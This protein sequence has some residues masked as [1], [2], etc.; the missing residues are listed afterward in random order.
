MGRA[1]H[2]HG[3]R[4][5][6]KAY[7][8]AVLSLLSFP[9]MAQETLVDRIAA[10]V[11][12]KPVMYSEIQK[13]IKKGQPVSLSQYPAKDSDS[14]YDKALNDEINY[15]LVLQKIEEFEIEISDADVD[16]EIQAFLKQ[17]NLSPAGLREA[18]RGQG[19]TYEEYQKDFRNQMIMRKFQGRVISPLI[20][21]TDKDIENYYIK[22]TGSTSENVRL[23]LRKIFISIPSGAVT[24]V[25]KAK[26]DRAKEVYGKLENGMDF[27]EAAKI[28]SDDP[29]AKESGGLMPAVKL[30]DLGCSH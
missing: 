19:M 21:I 12:G 25:R 11:N 26:E 4:K 1:S 30:N 3:K 23:R 7:L 28:Y 27:V 8:V 22:K 24:A 14:D 13:K 16:A 20:K 5:N 9:L 18:L 29:G 17:R 10:I 6:T 15:Q 2:E